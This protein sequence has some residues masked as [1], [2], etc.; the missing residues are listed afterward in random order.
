MRAAA[1]GTPSCSKDLAMLRSSLGLPLK[2]KA[3]GDEPRG[4]EP[5]AQGLRRREIDPVL[6][7]P[8][9]AKCVSPHLQV[10]ARGELMLTMLG[11]KFSGVDEPTL[12][13]D[14]ARARLHLHGPKMCPNVIPKC[15][16]SGPETG[17]ET[18]LLKLRGGGHIYES[19]QGGDSLSLAA[20]PCA[21]AL[22]RGRVGGSAAH[23]APLLLLVAAPSAWSPA[24]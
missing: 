6:D 11:G 7:W 12:L 17:V 3:C 24:A 10:A 5:S 1:E 22:E 15:A 19:F 16:Q 8:P 9:L 4:N 13:G 23:A 18:H 2:E 14:C 20:A 21:R